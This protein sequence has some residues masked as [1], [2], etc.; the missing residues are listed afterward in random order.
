MRYNIHMYVYLSSHL[1]LCTSKYEAKLLQ[2]VGIKT[3]LDSIF[4]RTNKMY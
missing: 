2:S 3:F 4:V 1:W